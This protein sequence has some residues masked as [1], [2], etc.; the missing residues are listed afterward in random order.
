[1]CWRLVVFV[2][3]AMFTVGVLAGALAAATLRMSFSWQCVTVVALFVLV[4]FLE[5]DTQRTKRMQI[6]HADSSQ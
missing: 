3:L 5:R 4:F 2:S 1:M 6:Q